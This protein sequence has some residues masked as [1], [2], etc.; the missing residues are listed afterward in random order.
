MQNIIE[1]LLPI[2]GFLS[3]ILIPLLLL[4]LADLR[5]LIQKIEQAHTDDGKIDFDEF[6]EIVMHTGILIKRIFSFFS[7]KP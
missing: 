7:S 4:V 3:L 5:S 6:M 2:F 1:Q